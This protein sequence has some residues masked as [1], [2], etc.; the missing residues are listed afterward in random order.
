[1]SV[2]YFKMEG[3]GEVTGTYSGWNGLAVYYQWWSILWHYS[4]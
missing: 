1:M 4:W 3:C 2:R